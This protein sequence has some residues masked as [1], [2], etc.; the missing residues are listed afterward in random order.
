VAERWFLKIDGIAGE[1]TD[2]A[3]K[4]EIDVESWSWGVSRSAGP[5]SG[6]GGGGSGKAAFDD[7]HF[8]SRISA[9]SP[10]LLLACATGTHIKEA[11]LSGA[12]GAGKSKSVDYLKYQLSDVTVTNVQ[13]FDDESE[14]PTEQ[15]S[16]NYSKVEV[17]YRPQTPSGKVGS[18]VT[19]GFDVKANKKI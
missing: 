12:R 5:G 10:P 4:G 15:F 9:A 19:F 1:S 6:G 17:T 16:L 18:P 13:Q 2:A 11:T 3:H 8:V 7:L 14:V